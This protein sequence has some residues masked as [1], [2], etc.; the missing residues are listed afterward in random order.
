MWLTVNGRTQHLFP[1]DTFE[2][3]AHQPHS[4][5]YGAKGAVYWVGRRNV[6][7]TGV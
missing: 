6:R 2:I 5:R 4:E 3:P 1:G 7:T